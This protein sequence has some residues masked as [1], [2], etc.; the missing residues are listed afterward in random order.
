MISEIWKPIPSWPGYDA[1]SHGRI[2]RS[3]V[4]ANAHPP[5]VL[6]GT[7]LKSGYIT[8]ETTRDG[9]RLTAGVHV[10]VCEAFHGPRPSET[11]QVRHLDGV[12]SHNAES[13]LAWGTPKE[14]AADRSKHGTERYGERHHAAKITEAMVVEIRRMKA[15]GRSGSEIG[16]VFGLNRNTINRIAVGKRWGHVP[17]ELIMHGERPSA[18]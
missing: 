6:A 2:R 9:Q 1:S 7:R 17:R 5:R 3:V 18:A 13:N 11:H 12:E 10:L 14:N 15:A 4:R 16:A 8:V